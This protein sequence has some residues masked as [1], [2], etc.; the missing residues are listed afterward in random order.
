[1]NRLNDYVVNYIRHVYGAQLLYRNRAIYLRTDDNIY[2]IDL[3]L[4]HKKVYRFHSLHTPFTLTDTNFDRGMFRAA[5]HGTYKEIG[6]IPTNKDWE[7]FMN[8]AYAYVVSLN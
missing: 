2:K 1:M 5:A 6:L 4:A 8:D 3:S 7:K